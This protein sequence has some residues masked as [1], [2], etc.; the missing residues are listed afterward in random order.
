MYKKNCHE[1]AIIHNIALTK[2]LLSNDNSV[3]RKGTVKFHGH[4]NILPGYK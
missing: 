1:T 4:Q 3:V 2:A